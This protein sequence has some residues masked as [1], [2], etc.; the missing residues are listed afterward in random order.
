[1][2]LAEALGEGDI[3]RAVSIYLL[4]R[5]IQDATAGGQ[6]DPVHDQFEVRVLE[7]LNGER[8]GQF[9]AAPYLGFI[10]GAKEFIGE[11]DTHEQALTD[12]LTRIK[13]VPFDRIFPQDSQARQ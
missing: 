4:H 13:G 3:L 9:R 12:A 5:P 8:K 7:Y 10:Y 2:K 11:G 6:S 1:M